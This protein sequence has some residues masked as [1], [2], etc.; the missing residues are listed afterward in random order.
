[1]KRALLVLIILHALLHLAGF[2]KAYHL[3]DA[4]T[5]IQN[6]SKIF[7]MFWL[8]T[9]TLFLITALLLLLDKKIWMIFSLLSIALSLYLVFAYWP[10]AWVGTIA[11]AI[12][13]LGTISSFISWNFNNK[14][15]RE[16][17]KYLSLNSDSDSILTEA[18]IQY[19]SRPVK[20][21][22]YYSF[23][24]EGLL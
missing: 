9:G 24:D 11:N 8:A 7:G 17:R 5:I 3:E 10:D 21:Y 16:I 4:N 1:M 22:M 2:G 20:N 15:K 6:V 23:A 14:Y 12:I 19:L 18:N 13:L